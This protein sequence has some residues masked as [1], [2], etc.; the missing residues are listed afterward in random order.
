M[1]NGAIV[2]DLDREH[3]AELAGE[4]WA[5]FM[6][7]FDAEAGASGSVPAERAQEMLRGFLAEREHLERESDGKHSD[8]AADAAIILDE[9]TMARARRAGMQ[10]SA[11]RAAARWRLAKVKYPQAIRKYILK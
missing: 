10:L 11:N 8:E 4:Q 3:A 9:E 2:G 7:A 5:D 1:G 6:H